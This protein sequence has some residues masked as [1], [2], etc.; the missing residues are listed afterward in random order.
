MAAQISYGSRPGPLASSLA[1]SDLDERVE[2]RVM[3]S[4]LCLMTEAW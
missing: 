4:A 3:N 2:I 1:L